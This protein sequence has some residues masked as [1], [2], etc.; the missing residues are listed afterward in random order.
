MGPLRLESWLSDS[1]RFTQW[2]GGRNGI[3]VAPEILGHC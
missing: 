2:L 1:L 3:K